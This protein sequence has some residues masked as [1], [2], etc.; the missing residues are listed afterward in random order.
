MRYLDR[1]HGLIAGHNGL[2][3]SG[4]CT[5][6]NSIIRIV[7]KYANSFTRLN[8]LGEFRQEQSRTT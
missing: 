8:K 3:L 6:E 5:L 1:Q 2:G 4:N 7:I